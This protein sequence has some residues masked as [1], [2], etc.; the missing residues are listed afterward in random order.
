MKNFRVRLSLFLG[1]LCSVRPSGTAAQADTSGVFKIHLDMRGVVSE[2][3]RLRMGGASVG[4][5][6]GR[7]RDEATLGYYWT[8]KRGKRDISSLPEFEGSFG[9]PAS[10]TRTDVRFIN[11]GYWMTIAN[12]RRWKLLTPLEAGIGRAKFSYCTHCGPSSADKEVR[13]ARIFPLQAAVYGEWKATRWVG[14]GLQV[15][16]RKYITGNDDVSLRQLEGLYYRLRVLVY[17]QTF[18]DWRNHLFR[19]EPLPSPFYEK[20]S[21]S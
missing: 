5:E 10:G 18:Y 3:K 13:R 15:G 11:A 12:R 6:W 2:G 8:G 4:W 1:L 9:L 7:K 20:A 17:I 21:G 16:Y 14:T 19:G